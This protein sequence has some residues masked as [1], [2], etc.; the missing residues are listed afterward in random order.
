VVLKEGFE[1]VEVTATA[2]RAGFALSD[3]VAKLYISSGHEN[4]GGDHHA[5]TLEL[6]VFYESDYNASRSAAAVVTSKTLDVSYLSSALSTQTQLYTYSR[7]DDILLKPQH[8][9]TMAAWGVS[10]DTVMADIGV[11]PDDMRAMNI[12][13]SNYGNSSYFTHDQLYA[14]RYYY[15]N[16]P[17]TAGAARVGPMLA[18]AAQREDEKTTSSGANM[19]ISGRFRLCRGMLSAQDSNDFSSVKWIYGLDIIVKDEAI[20]L[21][22]HEEDKVI[23][24]RE[25]DGGEGLGFGGKG[26]GGGPGGGG[27][28]APGAATA[29]YGGGSGGDESDASQL[30]GSKA[31]GGGASPTSVYSI[32]Q[33]LS[34][35]Q[36]HFTQPDPD[37]PLTAASAAV[38]MGVVL[39]G[40][41][42]AGVVFFGQTGR[43]RKDKDDDRNAKTRT[44][45]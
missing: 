41:A 6:R 11:H 27:G 23:E 14:A 42:K 22:P 4:D 20:V 45:A 19:V 43:R 3:V 24:F 28:G 30:T 26:A 34:D 25:G 7:W 5:D 38:A 9:G 1:Q 8:W 33:I 12:R 10:L 17:H 29:G 15:P 18:I 16:F 44:A 40:A 31:G 37:N 39:F 36:T 21:D 35:S 2:T 32:H 13:A